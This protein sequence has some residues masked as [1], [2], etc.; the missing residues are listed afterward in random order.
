MRGNDGKALQRQR[1]AETSGFDDGFLA[2]PGAQKCNLFLRR[3]AGPDEV[4]L[5]LGQIMIR[6]HRPIRHARDR[7]HI[8]A[9]LDAFM[10]ADQDEI[11]RMR[12][13]EMER[14]G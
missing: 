5:A 7:F 6:K 1:Q 9:D 14:T 13:I 4:A 2:C 10:Q 3:C 12:K 11:A 8:D